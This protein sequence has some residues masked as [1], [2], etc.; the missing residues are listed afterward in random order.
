MPSSQTRKD[1][2]APG[3]SAHQPGQGELPEAKAKAAPGDGTMH[4]SGDAIPRSPV[5]GGTVT[6]PPREG[7]PGA[8]SP[9]G[10][11]SGNAAPPPAAPQNTGKNG[12]AAK[13]GAADSAPPASE[14]LQ[15]RN[16]A[17]PGTGM[18]GLPA[19]GVEVTGAR[20]DTTS[21]FQNP[22]GT[23][24]LRAYPRPVHYRKADGSWDDIN[25]N[26]AL[27]RAGRWTEQANSQQA[28]F[29]AK[30]DDPALVSWAPG[31]GLVVSYG[32]QDAAQ[33]RGV[34]QG[35]TLTYPLARPASDVVYN[36]LA[37]GVKESLTLHDAT[38]PTSWV[39]P[40]HL[41]GLTPAIGPDGEVQFKD[42]SGA[43]KATIPH[44]FMT[45]S[46]I[47]PASG[48]GVV[49]DRV[50]YRL[51]D[52]NG[53]PAL[54]MDLDEVWLHD[55]KRV[56]PV[57]VDPSTTSIGVGKS[58]FVR[59][60]QTANF[61]TDP[62]LRIGTSDGGASKVNSYLYFPDVAGVLQ[63]NYLHAVTLNLN[64]THSYE[65]SPHPVYVNQITSAWDP[66]TINRYPGVSIGQQL[67]TASFSAG[68]TCG[69]AMW[70]SIDLGRSHTDPG[71]QLVESWARGA[72]NYGLA[73]TA[74]TTDSYH[75]KKFASANSAYPPYLSISYSDWAATYA[76]AGSYMP[77]TYNTPGY[78][79]V[80]LTNT[81]ANWWNS[82]SM[83]V[84]AR[85]FDTN[86]QE[87]WFNAPLTGVPGL[88]RTY[89]SVTINGV[90]PP[91]PLGQDYYLCW[92]GYVG[93][94]SSLHDNY[95]IPF[96]NCTTV[97][98]ANTAPQ[99][100]VLAPPHNTV[101]GSLTPQLY[102]TGHDPDNFPGSGLD[103]DF[104]V[105]TNP[106]SGDPELVA[107]SGWQSSTSWAVPPG[108]LAWNTG[109]LW[110]VKVGD[111][112]G[113]SP[114]SGTVSFSTQVQQPV[115]TSHLGGA[116]GDGAGRPFDAKVGNYTTAATDADVKSVGPALAVS[117]SYNSL[118]P[119]TSTLF[120]NGWTSNF[121]MKIQPDNDG[122]DS[123]VLTTAAGRAAR[124][125]ADPNKGALYTPPSG[126]FQS[127]SKVAAGFDLMAKDGTRYE[128][129]VASGNGYAL[130]LVR[131]AFSRTQELSY[132]NGVLA[133]VKDT[134]SGRTLHFEWTTG[135]RHVAKVSTDPVSGTDSNTALTW[136][137][138]YNPSNPDQLDQVCAPPTGGNTDRS[139]TGYSYTAGSH[140]RS[141]VLDSAPV[142]YWRLR[143]GSGGT[144]VS[145]VAEN[146]GN[147]NAT[148]S[149][150]GVTLGTP[151][152]TASGATAATFDGSSGFVGLPQ[153]VL[154]TSSYTSV[155]LW[156]KTSSWGVL[157]SYQA[158][159]FPGNGSTPANYT[160]ALYVGQSG[161]LHGKFWNGPSRTLDSTKAV[162]DGK[163]HYALLSAAGTTQTLYLDGEAQGA[164]LPGAVIAPGQRSEAVG[165]G[166]L[167]GGWPDNP[168]DNT[169][170][171]NYF[172]GSI[173]DVAFYNRALGEPAVKS[174]WQAGSQPSAQLT[175]LKLPSGKTR[176]GVSYD[177]VNDR[178]AKVTDENGGTWTLSQPTVAG[179]SQE[180]RGSVM[181]SR[182]NAYWRL[183]DGG[184]VQAANQVY[185]PRPTP[186]NGNYANVE[187]GSPGPMSGSPGSA[188][189]DGSTSWAELPA[190][191]APQN[192]PGALAL[193]FRTDRAGVLL[194]YQSFPVN[195]TPN[196]TT[197]QWNP[198]LYVDSNGRLRA[199]LWTGDASTT[200]ASGAPVNDNKWH[201]A[202]ISADS[203]TSQT[204]YLDGAPVAGPLNGT[205]IPNG[206]NHVFLGA[207][208]VTGRWP[209]P[210]ADRAGHFK[211]QLAD[212]AAY[213]HGL[214]AATISSLY[215]LATTSGATQ[216]DAAV[217]DSKPTGYWRLGDTTG[218]QATELISSAALAQN[219]GSYHNTTCCQAGPWASGTSTA[220]GFNGTNAYVQLPAN[221]SPKHWGAATVELWFKTTAPG[222]LYGYQSFP[223]D[224]KPNGSTDRWNPALYIGSDKKLYGTLWTGS[225]TNALVSATTVA[226]G[227]W[228][229][230]A[231]AGDGSGQT[232]YLDGAPTATSTTALPITYN[233]SAYASLGAGWTGGGWP[234]APSDQV[235]YFNGT[236]ADFS[237]FRYRLTK[238]TVS[239]HYNRATSAAVVG[240]LDA[241]SNYRAKTVQDGAVG[242]WRLNDPSGSSY[243]ASQLGDA[244]PDATA[245]NLTDVD[246]NAAGPSGDQSQRAGV[247]NGSTSQ[248]QLPSDAAPIR[249]AASVELWFK[250]TT[251]GP[252]Y[253]YQDYPVGT[254]GGT[255]WN[256]A[257][258]VGTDG[259]VHGEFWMGLNAS[260]TSDRTV[261]DGNW[262]Q[263]V[264][265]GDDSGQ[266]IYID[267]RASASDTTGR[268]IT[269]NGTPYVYLGA[270]STNGWPAA[271]GDH[272]KGTI[273]EASY[274][275]SRLNADTVTAHYKAMGDGGKPIPVTTAT[276]TDPGG[277][278]L[279]YQYDTR[280]S[281]LISRTDGYGN[282][283]RYTYDTAGYLYAVSDPNGHTIT[284][285]HDARGNTVSRTT[286]RGAGSCQTSYATY[287]LDIGNP[288]NT[289]NDKILTSSDARS[290]GPG[291]TTYTTRYAYDNNGQLASTT[292]PATPD[293]PKGRVSYI[294]R[295]KAFTPAPDG[296]MVP[297]GL[298]RAQTVLLDPAANPDP[299]SVPADKQTEYFYQGNGDV[300]FVLSPLRPKVS[301]GYDNLGRTTSQSYSCDD[302]P[303]GTTA[304]P[305]VLQTDYTWDGQG[306]PVTRTDP[307]TTDAVTGTKHTRRTTTAY[308]VDGN[309]VS[310]TV[311]DTTGGD[312]PRT[313]TWAYESDT[314]RVK[315]VKDPGGHA[316]SYT[317][318][319]YGNVATRTDAAGTTYN[320]SHSPMG[321]LQQT[322]VSNYTGS[323]ASPT[324]PRWQVIGSRGYDPAGRLATDTDAMGR[325]THTYYNDDNTI[326]E[327]DLDGYHNADGSLRNVVLQ[328]NTYDDAG[329]LAQQVTGGGKTTTVT[330]YDAAGRVSR[331]TADPGG[332]NR[333]T[334]YTYDVANRPTAVIS[335]GGADA[336]STET[337]YTYDVTGT[338]LKQ[339]ARNQPTDS[340]VTY[341]YN[342]RGLRTTTVSPNG[343]ATGADPVP[344][345]S[346][347][348]YDEAGRPTVT[349][350]P[351]VSAETYDPTS[352]G[353]KPQQVRPISRTGYDTFG[354]LT[355]QVD[356]LG[357][358]VTYT[359]DLDGNRVAAAGAAY[360]DPQSGTTITPTST[361][362][363]DVLGRPVTSVVD[364]TGLKLTHTMQ[365]DQF[366]RLVQTTLP[367][368]GGVTAPT[369]TNSYDLDG[370]LLSTTG[371]TGA[372]SQATYD[373]LGRRITSTQLERYPA[374]AAYTSTFTWDD[375]GNQLS[376]TTPGGATS[377]ATYNAVGQLLSAT[378]PAGVTVRSAYDG[379]GRTSRVTRA[380]GT[381]STTGYDGLGRTLSTT[382][383]DTTGAAVSTQ[384]ATYDLEGNV[385]TATDKVASSADIA[386]HARQFTYNP[387]GLPVQQVEPVAAGQTITTSFGYDSGGR[388]TR[389]TNGKNIPT[390]Y[391][392]N[393]L[394]LPESTVEPPT[395]AH[396]APAEG[397]FTT[398]Y[399][400]AGRAVTLTEP[401]NVVRRRSYDGAGNLTQETAAGAEAATP[402]RTLGYDA[403]GHLISVGTPGTTPDTYTYND[404][405]QLLTTAGPG[406]ASSYSYNGDSR[407]TARTDTAGTT[408]FGYNTAGQLT[409]ATDPLTGTAVGYGYDAAGRLASER[410]GT[411]G[412]SR[413]YGYD[414]LGRLRD[415]TIK[416]PAG[417]TVASIGYGYDLNSR[418]TSKTTGGTAGA[419]TNQYG[420]DL[421]GRLT[422]W[423]NGTTATAYTWDAAGNRTAAGGTT[424]TFD[425]RNELLD[426]GSTAYGYSARGTLTSS[427]ARG[428]QPKD[429]Q[430]DGF[431]RMVKEGPSTYTYDSLDRVAQTGNATF[432]YDGG[433]NNLVSDGTTTYTRTPGATLLGTATT[434]ATPNP[435]LVI[436]DQHTD[437]VATIDPAAKGV[438]GSTAYDPFGKPTASTGATNSL[439]YQ[440]GWTDPA[441]GD[442]NMAARWYRPGSGTFASRDSWQLGPNPSIRGNRFTY[443]DGDPVDAT[444]PSGHCPICAVIVIHIVV[445]VA[446]EIAT[447]PPAHAPGVDPR[448]R[449]DNG[450][451]YNAR[452]CESHPFV[453]SCGG[454]GWQPTRS[455]GP[456][457]A[458]P[459]EP[460]FIPGPTGGGGHGGGGG[461]RHKPGPRK[462]PGPKPS[463]GPIMP[464]PNPPTDT[465]PTNDNDRPH[466]DP[467]P[468]D[469]FT[470]TIVAVGTAVVGV[471]IV[472]GAPVVVGAATAVGSGIVAGTGAV[473]DLAD[474][475]Y[476]LIN[477]GG[478]PAPAPAPAPAPRPWP[479]PAPLPDPGPDNPGPGGNGN[480][481]VPTCEDLKPS[482]AVALSGGGWVNYLPSDAQGRNTGVNACL[483]GKPSS[484]RGQAA[485]GNIRGWDDA[486]KRAATLGF[487]EDSDVARCHSVPRMAGGTTDERNLTPCFQRGANINQRNGGVITN[488]MRTFETR[489]GKAMPQG[490]VLYDVL[491]Q[492]NNDKSTIPNG[493]GMGFYG[494]DANTGLRTDSDWTVVDNGAFSSNGYVN[495]GN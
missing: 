227:A 133:T 303:G 20:T 218:N 231:L 400:A 223:L 251:G 188:T 353:S 404:R 229:H 373:D 151:G 60:D 386:A 150:T 119:R 344:Y 285:G 27:D 436:S 310:Q 74:S 105:Y 403:A 65:C 190:A 98:G 186:N 48:D 111:H 450:P 124:F 314:S 265:T 346:S 206:T 252:L 182:P 283:T 339:T 203:Q 233:G 80:T 159:P 413:S 327:I 142:S 268:K 348:G 22:D 58:T 439:G 169:G 324:A 173:S 483:E 208:N 192:G 26:F 29:A 266:T 97:H 1:G 374:A 12:K 279:T 205:I 262:H 176:L 258:Y 425:E 359:Y 488:S 247:F 352:R 11:Q 127:L 357:N 153:S 17:T 129:H 269:F 147:D 459:G 473:I 343:N 83:Q 201:F 480:R 273:A 230:V 355:S 457:P 372:V 495:L 141:A 438:A 125:G 126:E 32:L 289:A 405:G 408:A 360:T 99:L 479:I 415:D 246:L 393:S 240:G 462:R 378:D 302:C 234:N 239:G 322:A 152:P 47:D 89:D 160:P 402:N 336:N 271:G 304:A 465:R 40:L 392:Y 134:S 244:R 448:P 333:T 71:V 172:N 490:P 220:T 90:I 326:A 116:V 191:Y 260:M 148:Y 100:D 155:G 330:A 347:V 313:T 236:I 216:Y 95:W 69:G 85:L 282:T 263:A 158:D 469:F 426:D 281:R 396:P 416:N 34:V 255:A 312:Q 3:E 315:Q 215:Q 334:A 21:L 9:G 328:Q 144:A 478:N 423:N 455:P 213:P 277:Y 424:S 270:G 417:T 412:G 474:D 477:G 481:R 55:A 75:W 109:Y 39:F 146:Q 288:L 267:G 366:G 13:Q 349:T 242:Y 375:A 88:V 286:C 50:T 96:G 354:Q 449:R 332:L 113:E 391:T 130:S 411:N 340:V 317:Y 379:L 14:D 168:Y 308:D 493:W 49:S 430:F 272:F 166:F 350:G 464:R 226:D 390:Y 184:G 33:V 371:P 442:V 84:K 66:A 16:D 434:G 53:T 323:S 92:D 68:D 225:A 364:P 463:P 140:L 254:Q 23:K 181:G 394:G 470:D 72:D 395:T 409:S 67:G 356:P 280:S 453:R 211:G 154:D 431:D 435:R 163:W 338:L 456:A 37:Q 248:V 484:S 86:W 250:T 428:S 128:F 103:Y 492:Y 38:A 175:G 487:P 2:G 122:S 189:F 275:S 331:T 35:D 167:S 187:L 204:L 377:K 420:Y 384:Y 243:A 482:G 365:Y 446:I 102:A 325:T 342:S 120:G 418:I 46:K 59:S 369:V 397:L 292:L 110:N 118:D 82:Q 114:L 297:I 194:S 224:G 318:D 78:Q 296:S 301:Y 183:S 466:T 73:L 261:N 10:A 197:D 278:K 136:T 131:D 228:H 94:T 407:M 45:D 219:R 161:Y 106:A 31:Q 112:G 476:N 76:P 214:N 30:T 162:N 36:G 363:Y 485:T 419:A 335:T 383:L 290:S 305:R 156:F 174:L 56:F 351:L 149:G 5:K 180:Y 28:T 458:P 79:Q 93:G 145:E 178:A 8:A 57:T 70:E 460:V 444:D 135:N 42:A 170:H 4:P 443:G 196:G 389:W 452:Y 471:V 81:G 195:G 367:P 7:R 143:E 257:L 298:V 179:S 381:A 274:Y 467:S 414:N 401:G 406:G 276:V 445:D 295:T 309:Q 475:V 387:A 468:I 362:E 437:V 307:Y 87:Q 385:L 63:N 18:P 341:G 300:A 24:T 157:F 319:R 440:S 299:F 447:A 121:D 433:S 62:Q 472:E 422:S 491:P 43:V 241:A 421:A 361:V 64:N 232:L 388:K 132:G 451:D 306:N 264:L 321:Q 245:G 222:V 494:W 51:V 198:A 44:G 138:T 294:L 429:V 177:A 199:Q 185:T 235:S 316:T 337:D 221:T 6:P 370:E 311:A 410:Y 293:F 320:F 253:G 287:Y 115:I 432:T 284:T 259:R 165:G 345:T 256:P 217:V 52:V 202:V 107:E 454:D 209:Q 54:R 237:I 61:S 382:G 200:L 441:S 104:R 486:K 329:H 77:P 358:T 101:I 238:D 15:A 117:R 137:Y 399:D 25:T 19:E 139:C 41:T 427:T 461:S 376:S 291:D 249:G 171:A 212:V 210:P 489:A 368:T 380:D 108:K 91:L 123:V 193:W 164:P 398:S 207:G